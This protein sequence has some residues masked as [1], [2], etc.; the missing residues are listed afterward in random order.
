[1]K[2][3]W[4]KLAKLQVGKKIELKRSKLRL[5]QVHGVKIGPV[6]ENDGIFLIEKSD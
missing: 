4:M 2:Y 6:Y 1:M 3:I 5:F